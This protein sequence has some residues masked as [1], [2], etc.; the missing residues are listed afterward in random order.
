MLHPNQFK[1]NEAW[2]AFR[3]ND[4]PI[5]TEKDGGFHC[6]AVMDAAS[7]FMLGTEMFSI[8]AAPSVFQVRLLL[9]KCQAHKQALPRTLYVASDDIAEA[10]AEE[11][12]RQKIAVVRVAERDV[13]VFIGE[14]KQMFVERFGGAGALH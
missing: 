10:V 4:R 3:I 14:A 5:M 8:A 1:V 7:C 12:V 11:A 13:E 6:L 2:I 9:K